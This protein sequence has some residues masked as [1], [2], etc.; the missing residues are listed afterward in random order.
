MPGTIRLSVLEFIDLPELLPSPISIKVSMGKR[1]YE[2]SD[3][4]EFSFPLTT[5]R[6]DVILIVQ[7]AGGNEISRAG[8][9]NS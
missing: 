1:H 7:D 2:T 3:K 9:I 8:E 4:G 5:L 6:D